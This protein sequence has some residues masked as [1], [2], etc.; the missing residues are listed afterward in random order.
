M[1]ALDWD[2]SVLANETAHVCPKDTNAPEVSA[3]EPRIINIPTKIP[4]NYRRSTLHHGLLVPASAR[5]ISFAQPQ[6]Q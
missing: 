2:M 4:L 3:S 5:R 6:L 1:L